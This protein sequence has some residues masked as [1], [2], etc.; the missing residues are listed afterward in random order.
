MS[1]KSDVPI[2]PGVRG[3]PGLPWAILPLALLLT[4]WVVATALRDNYQSLE[5]PRTGERFALSLEPG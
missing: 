5:D 4:A 1:P 3:R 2:L